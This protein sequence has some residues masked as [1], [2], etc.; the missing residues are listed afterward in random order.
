MSF[1]WWQCPQN[2][3][4]ITSVS[5]EGHGQCGRHVQRKHPRINFH[6][7]RILVVG[8]GLNHLLR[9]PVIEH[10]HDIAVPEGMR[11]HLN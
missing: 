9:L 2:L 10:V 5:R 3:S 8:E 1:Q 11:G 4:C 6:R 7:A